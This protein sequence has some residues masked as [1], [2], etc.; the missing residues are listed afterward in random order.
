MPWQPAPQ[1]D[2]AEF[3]GVPVTEDERSGIEHIPQ[4]ASGKI[5]LMRLSRE[6]YK[7]HGFTP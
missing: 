2:R 7:C 4:Q 6:D 3:A 1:E 5:L